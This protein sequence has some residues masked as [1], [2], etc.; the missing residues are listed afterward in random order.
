MYTMG[1]HG[2]EKMRPA[3]SMGGAWSHGEDGQSERGQG[4]WYRPCSKT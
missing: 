4:S 2:S 1:V 3:A